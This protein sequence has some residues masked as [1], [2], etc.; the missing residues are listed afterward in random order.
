METK[1]VVLVAAV[2][3]YIPRLKALSG[4][5]VTVWA[6]GH[7]PYARTCIPACTAGVMISAWRSK[8]NPNPTIG[9]HDQTY[10]QQS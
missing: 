2:V 4:P 3:R 6:L 1:G 8:L 5:D 9:E 10:A 7:L